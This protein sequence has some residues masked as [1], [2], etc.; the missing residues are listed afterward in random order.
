[1]A[2]LKRPKGQRPE[3]IEGAEELKKR[4]GRMGVTQ[5]ELADLLAV[6]WNTVR[7]WETA[8]REIPE[9]AVRLME[10]L[11]RD[12]RVKRPKRKER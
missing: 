6:E 9:M 10:Y 3:L 12:P 7:R 2:T 5:E 8:Q 4:R 1:M 11:E